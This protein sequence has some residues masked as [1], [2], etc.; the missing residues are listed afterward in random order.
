MGK[1]GSGHRERRGWDAPHPSIGAGEGRDHEITSFHR[2]LLKCPMFR[3]PGRRK[4]SGRKRESLG[5]YG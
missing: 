1:G 4:G 3:Y 2:L 5:D